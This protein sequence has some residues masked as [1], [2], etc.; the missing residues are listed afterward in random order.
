MEG[1]AQV[2]LIM[3]KSK[4]RERRVNVYLLEDETWMIDALEE[5]LKPLN[6]DG[7][8]NSKG[9]FNKSLAVRY[10]LKEWLTPNSEG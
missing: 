2:T 7:M 6:L 9:E 5:R 8:Y 4:E 1:I 3:S 10:A